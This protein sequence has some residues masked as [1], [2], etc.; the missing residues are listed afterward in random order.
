MMMLMIMTAITTFNIRRTEE[1]G[2]MKERMRGGGGTVENLVK[3]TLIN[4]QDNI[5]G[6]DH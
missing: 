5:E 4:R 2:K 3:N 1:V 6:A